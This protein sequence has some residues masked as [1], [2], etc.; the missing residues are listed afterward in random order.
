MASPLAIQL[1][2]DPAPVAFSGP[3]RLR[4]RTMS[5]GDID[6]PPGVSSFTAATERRLYPRC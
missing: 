4:Y 2:A 5:E 1:C 6:V 3:G